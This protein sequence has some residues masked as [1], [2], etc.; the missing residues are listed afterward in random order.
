VSITVLF[1]GLPHTLDLDE[2]LDGTPTAVPLTRPD[3]SSPLEGVFEAPFTTD[4]EHVTN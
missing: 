4:L 2:P 3:V 1:A